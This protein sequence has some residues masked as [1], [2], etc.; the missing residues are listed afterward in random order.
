MRQ[1]G[2]DT[3]HKVRPGRGFFSL[4]FP[5]SLGW[6]SSQPTFFLPSPRECSPL[7]TYS[8]VAVRRGRHRGRGQWFER[9]MSC[10][11]CCC[12]C[13][14]RDPHKGQP[15]AREGK[16]GRMFFRQRSLITVTLFLFWGG[17]KCSLHC[18]SECLGLL[19]QVGVRRYRFTIFGFFFFDFFKFLRHRCL[20]CCKRDD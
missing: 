5:I 20:R 3:G 8:E 7:P 4:C 1:C 11:P 18:R 14:S 6:E 15:E 12:P 10:C 2:L 9:A 17:F 16:V 19:F 13:R